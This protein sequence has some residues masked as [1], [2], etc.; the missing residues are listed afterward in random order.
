MSRSWK[1]FLLHRHAFALYADK[2][3]LG[4]REYKADGTRGEYIWETYAAV[5]AKINALG[6]FVRTLTPKVRSR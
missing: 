3:Y 2:K 6:S 1:P 4:H 5:E